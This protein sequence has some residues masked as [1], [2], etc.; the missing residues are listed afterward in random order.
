M[1]QRRTGN[2]RRGAALFTVLVVIMAVSA[3]V[4]IMISAGMQ[5]SF[6]AKRLGDEL[7]AQAIAEAGASKAFSLLKLDFGQ[8]TN[9]AAFPSENYGG[10][11]YKLCVTPVGQGIAIVAS[12]GVYNNVESDVILNVTIHKDGVEGTV[13]DLSG[14]DT[15]ILA[16]GEIT[17]TGNSEFSEGGVVHANGA[18]GISGSGE[19]DP[20][21]VTSATSIKTTGNACLLD[22]NAKAP[23][24][25]DSKDR[26]AGTK[27]ESAVA[28]ITLPNLDLTPY[29][30]HALANG[31]V[32]SGL[33][34]SGNFTPAGGVA[35]VNG[36][37][38]ISGNGTQQGCFIATGDI[39]LTGGTHSQIDNLP[40]FISRDGDI[41][42]AGNG[43]YHGLIYTRVGDIRI[44]GTCRLYGSI[45]CGGD[46]FKSGNSGVF[47]YENAR[48]TPPGGESED[49]FYY[50]A[51]WQK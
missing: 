22:G 14:Y 35:W 34:I 25:S 12:T 15:V 4:G 47:A 28:A 42:M 37:L 46:L 18:F 30:N 26:I 33:S 6:T 21:L 39:S 51:I 40:A 2:S 48:P 43:D 32:Y 29:Y 10:G 36:N 8:R 16:A 1:K 9:A 31:Q 23:T 13:E 24:I 19:M 20:D 50:T 44:T 3:L 45:L 11:L 17:W 49:G 41:K 38:S 5:R 7:R 27:T